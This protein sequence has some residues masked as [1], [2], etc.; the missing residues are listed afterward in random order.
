MCG[1]SSKIAKGKLIKL[2]D[3]TD[4]KMDSCIF[5]GSSKERNEKNSNVEEEM[6]RW[7]G[8]LVDIVKSSILMKDTTISNS[9]DGGITMSGGEMTVNDGRFENNNPFV[10]K[11]P[12]LRRNIICSDSA[13]LTISSLKGGDGLMSNSSL[14][15]LNDGCTLGGIAGERL[16]PF[17]IPKLE[18]ASLIENGNNVSI[19]F[20]GTLLLPCDLSFRLIFKTGDVE[21]VETYQFDENSFVSEDEVIGT[22][23]SENISTIANE[24]EVSVMILFGKQF[25]STP[26]QKL[27]N[28]SKSNVNG[29]ERI[30]EG[31]KEEK[32]T[33][34]LIVIVV[35]G[36]LFVIS[37]LI[38]VAVVVL[39]RKKL[40][41]AEK[42]VEKE[43][44]ENEEIMGKLERRRKE[45]NGG[46][47]EMSEMP[48]TLLEGMTSQIPLLIDNDEEDLP[49]P[50]SMSNDEILNEN[51]VPDLESPLPFSE[52]ASASGV[53]QSHSLNVI[54]AKKPF[55]EKEKKNIKTLHSVIHSVQGNFTLGTRAMDVVDGKEVILAVAELFEHLISVGDERVEMMGSQ[56]CPYTIFVEEGNENEIYLLTEK[57]ADEK[58]KEEMKR[59]KA[60]EAGDEEEGIEKAVVFSLGLILH[61]MTTVEVPL[62]GVM[63][64]KRR[65]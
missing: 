37:M 40:R 11:Y 6:C 12:S 3:C 63:R 60:P 53:P 22:I 55:R 26:P 57:L 31:G 24:T 5:D 32:S 34:N 50:P 20:K 29:D 13:S 18:E 10:Q 42:K 2:E 16:S 52:N 7:S 39:L 28:R 54:S 38:F 27:K 15:I 58:Q 45:N 43:R 47:F 61:E 44:L 19:K 4:V 56:L 30:V 65:R 51:D 23:P 14:W 48:S 17:F 62:S 46:S 21:L 41:E 9:P 25:A 64:M 33:W 59:W 49:D 35:V 1:V 36:V 8:S